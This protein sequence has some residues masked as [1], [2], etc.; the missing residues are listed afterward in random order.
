[1]K[2]GLGAFR[3]SGLVR[4]VQLTPPVTRALHIVHVLTRLLP[5][6]TEEN[7]IAIARRQRQDGHRVT[8][9][10]G[11]QH[12]LALLNALRGEFE[13]MQVPDLVHRISPIHDLT[14]FIRLRAIL[15][16]LS[17]DVVHTHQ[18][19]AGVVA[20]AA[21]AAAGVKGVVHGVHILP[22]INAGR[23]RA[24]AYV[25]M[26]RA[27]AGA[28]NAFISVSSGV[29]DACLSQGIGG[30]EQHFVVH[31]PIEIS[32]FKQAKPADDVL[33]SEER[34]GRT[35]VL[36]LAA[37]E[38]RKRQEEFLDALADASPGEDLIVLFA[39][40]GPTLGLA[41]KKA[42]ARFRPGQI[43]FLGHREDPERLIALADICVL[44]SNREGLPRVL[45][46]Y[47]A[48]GRASV[49]TDL[50][51]LN[52]VVRPDVNAVVADDIAGAVAELVRLSHDKDAR[53]ALASEA[54]GTDLS[55]WDM[56]ALYPAL[57]RAYEFAL[58]QRGTGEC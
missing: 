26:E 35:V 30:A 6:G 1:M 54:A 42:E 12:S 2:R 41:R 55:G 4:L 25:A 24:A 40:D 22:W 57:E 17:P 10:H 23:L 20:S 46:Q 19:K 14:S 44:T 48:G 5:A 58:A 39:G 15:R 49:V 37:F 7:T 29:R 50:P 13:V 3:A 52:D 18:S 16:V 21:A 32:R 56:N 51:G 33:S 47:L 8:F 31:S 28:S 38:P 27:V 45:L 34:S 53:H 11:R 9:I 36:M 43:R